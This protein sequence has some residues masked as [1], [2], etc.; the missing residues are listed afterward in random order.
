MATDNLFLR[1]SR[2]S[3]VNHPSYSNPLDQLHVIADFMHDLGEIVTLKKA[4]AKQVAA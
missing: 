3:K 2:R 1:C 4:P